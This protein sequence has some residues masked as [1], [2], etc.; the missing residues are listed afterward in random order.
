MDVVKVFTEEPVGLDT[1]VPDA[2]PDARRRDA[3]MAPLEALLG[4]D[5]RPYAR[6]YISGTHLHDGDRRVGATAL[7]A[8]EAWVTPL[9]AWAGASAWWSVDAS[10]DLRRL[11]RDDAVA[12]LAAPGPIE[13]M[14]LGDP[15]GLAD[16]VGEERRDRLPAL[17]ALLD[18]GTAVLFPEPAFDGHDWSLF[19]LAPLRDALADAFR[20]HPVPGVRRLFAPFQRAR[21]EHKFYLEQWSLDDLPAWA[22]EL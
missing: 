4:Q 20:Q 19:A 9:A 1:L 3:P 2:E 22:E 10:G 11:T 12:A 16:A 5:N 21:G 13:A 17:R 8:P 14:A 18:R 15:T 7:D 6:A